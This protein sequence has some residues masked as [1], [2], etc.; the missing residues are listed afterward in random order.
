MTLMDAGKGRDTM[1]VHSKGDDD[2]KQYTLRNIRPSAALCL[3]SASRAAL[4]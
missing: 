1:R 4:T 3:A 2:R